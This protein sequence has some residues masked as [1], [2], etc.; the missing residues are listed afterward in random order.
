MTIF[1]TARRTVGRLAV[2]GGLAAA[3]LVTAPAISMILTDTIASASGNTAANGGETHGGATNGGNGV[4]QLGWIYAIQ[5]HV[6]VPH[7]DTT[8]HQ[9]R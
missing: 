9:M 3:A 1:S 7:V 5:P 2:A 8:V 6:Y 4:G